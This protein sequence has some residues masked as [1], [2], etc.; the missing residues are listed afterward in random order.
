MK[1]ILKG[2]TATKGQAE[3]EALVCRQPVMFAS[4]VDKDSG[5]VLAKGHELDG[6]NVK[7]KVIVYPCACG[8]AGEEA[9]LFML[10]KVGMVPKAIIAGSINHTPSI[11]GAIYANIPMVYGFD[12]NCLGL[13]NNGDHVKVD[14]DNGIV[15]V[16]K[17]DA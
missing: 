5:V 8:S 16:T 17:R 6:K 7:D 4:Y 15:E 3:S 11:V 14:A 2:R 10:S 13:I 9:A 1:I 12:Q